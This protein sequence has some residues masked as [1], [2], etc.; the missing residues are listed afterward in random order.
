VIDPDGRALAQAPLWKA[1][2]VLASPRL[3][4][5]RGTLFTCTGDG[6][7]NLALLGLAG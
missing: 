7:P 5:G 4:D 3:G 1:A 2:S 6:P